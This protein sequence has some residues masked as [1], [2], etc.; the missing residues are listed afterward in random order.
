M[1][2]GQWVVICC[3]DNKL[4]ST[5]VLSHQAANGL[6]PTFPAERYLQNISAGEKKKK[7]KKGYFH[8][9]LHLCARVINKEETAEQQA[10]VVRK[11]AG[12]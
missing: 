4:C 3:S 8:F 10:G 5:T 11:L 12:K 2:I 9:F 1:K 6:S 7:E